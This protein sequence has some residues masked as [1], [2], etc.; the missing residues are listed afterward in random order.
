MVT[1]VWPSDDSTDDIAKAA[2]YTEPFFY[3]ILALLAS[4]AFLQLW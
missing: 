4:Q 1:V 2:F 3:F